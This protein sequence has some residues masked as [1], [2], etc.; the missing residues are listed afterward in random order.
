[1]NYFSAILPILS[2]ALFQSLS[3]SAQV[4]AESEQPASSIVELDTV[5]VSGTMPAPGLWELTRG[6]KRVLIMGTLKP[7]PSDMTWHS[8]EVER[9]VAQAQEVLAPPGVSVSADVG[10]FRGAMLWPAYRR[11]RRNPDGK[12]LRDMLPPATYTRWLDAKSRYIGRDGGI[13]KLR[14]VYAAK[15]LFDAATRQVGLSNE[16]RID[17]VI[18]RVAKAHKI[19]VRPTVVRIAIK[20]A[21]GTLKKLSQ[22][23]LDDVP[24]LEQTINR[25]DIDLQMMVTRANAWAMGDLARL[26]ALPYNDQKDA[27]LG[28]LASNEI[29]RSQGIVDLDA[30]VLKNWLNALQASLATYDVVFATMPIDRIEGEAG[31]LSS[32]RADGFTVK[33]PE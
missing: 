23:T 9:A 10:L 14:P 27:C 16:D 6:N 18:R 19:P 4:P 1:M 30:A 3:V 12:K 25:L 2:L 32:L 7:T 21:K 33:S 31:V 26:R 8:H 13:E 28:A 22:T 20:D 17:P 5:V 24:C 11:S 29:A 15:T